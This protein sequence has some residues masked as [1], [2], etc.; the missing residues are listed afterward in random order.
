MILH[1]ITQDQCK[2]LDKMWSIETEEE[3][4][5]WIRGLPPVLVKEVMVLR[6]MLI[7]SMI[8]EELE[9]TKDTTLARQMIEKCR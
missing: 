6:E 8:D 1:G 3:L 2:L 5:D 7:L 4:A 9:E